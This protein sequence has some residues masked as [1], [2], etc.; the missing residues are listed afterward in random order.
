MPVR[1]SSGDHRIFVGD[2]GTEVNDDTLSKAFQKYPS[3]NKAKV[4]ESAVMP[5]RLEGLSAGGVGD[6]QASGT[7]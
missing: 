6:G 3:F 7:P 4:R 1:H 2:L 5:L